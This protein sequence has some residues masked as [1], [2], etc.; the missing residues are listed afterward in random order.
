MYTA[1]WLPEYPVEGTPS[2]DEGRPRLHQQTRNRNHQ[3]A[4]RGPNAQSHT[5]NAHR[6]L[7][8]RNPTQHLAAHDPNGQ[9]HTGNGHRKHHQQ[10][11]NQRQR[12]Y[13]TQNKP[14]SYVQLP[15]TGRNSTQV[16]KFPFSEDGQRSESPFYLT[17]LNS[18]LSLYPKHT[19]NSSMKKSDNHNGVESTGRSSYMCK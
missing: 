15:E 17:K 2:G 1:N 13:E 4:S 12:T 8:S 10:Q 9:S 14:Q 5:G 16:K 7:Q 11:P 19:F 18:G 6:N 3:R